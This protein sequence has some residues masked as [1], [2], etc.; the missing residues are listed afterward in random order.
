MRAADT[1]ARASAGAGSGSRREGIFP[2]AGRRGGGHAR[3]RTDEGQWRLDDEDR[4]P[5][6]GLG[7]RATQ[8]G[9]NCRAEHCGPH[10]QLALRYSVC[11][12]ERKGGH[13]TAGS[14]NCLEAATHEEGGHI[15]R[16]GAHERCR[17]EERE[18]GHAHG[19]VSADLRQPP[20]AQQRE[21]QN[22]CVD[23]DHRRHAL[24]RGVELGEQVGER[25]RD[26]RSVG[27][28]QPGG[29]RKGDGPRPHGRTLFMEAER[30]SPG[31]DGLLQVI[32]PHAALPA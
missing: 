30:S 24:D 13:Q 11:V 23:A 3:A 27:Q 22:H 17:R 6:E 21:T 7:E 26:D 10:P 15:V 32:D 19:P 31:E 14:P 12:Q 16:P 25:Q 8:R 4:A 29:A 2:L 1:S 5:V 18:P 28:R 9:A 20:S